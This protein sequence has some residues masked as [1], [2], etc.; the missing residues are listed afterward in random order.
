M[1][2]SL[3]EWQLDLPR[4]GPSARTSLVTLGLLT[5]LSACGGGSEVVE[6]H[7]STGSMRCQGKTIRHE[8]GAERMHGSWKFWY[9]DGQIQ[10][11]GTFEEGTVLRD[12]D[13]ESTH[14]QIPVQGRTGEWT[15][16]YPG[17][18]PMWRGRF[19]EGERNGPW[20]WW[21]TDGSTK[22][23]VEFKDGKMDGQLTR[24][25]PTGEV[26]EEGLYRSFRKAQACSKAPRA[27]PSATVAAPT[28]WAL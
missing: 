4:S 26:A 19:R 7:Y 22:A 27:M 1:V 12:A 10:A 18:R 5:L 15:A 28:R 11:E 17:G 13:F 14:T 24:W 23:R 21:Y 6:K 9:D 3:P 2:L 8:S 20:I 16:Y 25:H